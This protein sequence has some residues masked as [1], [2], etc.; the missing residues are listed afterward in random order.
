[1]GS[2]TREPPAGGIGTAGVGAV[3]AV[4]ERTVP[5]CLD[6]Y[7]ELGRTPTE[8]HVLSPQ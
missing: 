2:G 8:T 4:G 7:G 1:M 6:S 3:I 5:C